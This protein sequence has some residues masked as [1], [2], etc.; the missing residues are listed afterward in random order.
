[1]SS[2][3]GFLH[4]AGVSL[5]DGYAIRVDFT[6]GATHDVDLTGDLH[7][8]VFEPLRDPTLFARAV[9]NPETGTVEWPNGADFAP[10]FLYETGRR[11]V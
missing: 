5:H 9:V 7:G 3:G 10:K 1:M 11:V 6:N 4:A 2:V 8:E